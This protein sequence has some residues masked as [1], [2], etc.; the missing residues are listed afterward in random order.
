MVRSADALRGI[1]AQPPWRRVTAAR[2]ANVPHIP[3]NKSPGRR[4]VF[5]GHRIVAATFFF[6]LVF[7]GCGFYAFGLFVTPLETE[8]AWTRREIMTG[9][10]IYFLT[11]GALG[12]LI[13][14][15]VDRFGPRGVMV[16]GALVSGAGFMLLGQMQQLWQFYAVYPFIGAGMAAVGIVPITAVVSNWYRRRRGM[17]IGI[18]SAGLGAGGLALA[19]LIGGAIIPALGW[20]IAYPVMAGFIW[21]IIPVVLLVIRTRPSDMGLLPD[22]DEEPDEGTAPGQATLPPPGLSLREAIATGA[23]WLTALSFLAFGFSEVTIL[24]NQVPFLEGIGF[25][26]ALA[27]GVLGGV[28]L[29]S[30]I[31]KFGFGWLCDRV[32]VKYV[33]AFGL[34]L[35]FAGTIVLMNI[36]PD[37]SE[38]VLWTYA[39]LMGLGVGSWLPA[40]SML[41]SSN[42]G[43]ASYGVIF[44][45]IGFVQAAGGATGPL[46]AGHLF[47]TM[48]TYDLVFILLAGSY[49]VSTLSVLAVRRPASRQVPAGETVPKT[50]II[51]SKKA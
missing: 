15:L 40:M 12:P 3:G 44:G 20:R 23:F 11:S 35:Q 19:P 43:M 25:P 47:D 38:A 13:G 18:M 10:T 28:G 27:A 2:K 9:S 46:M 7:S 5:Y 14:R 48:G 31:G 51:D 21:A 32:P 30:T 34:A 26:V 6:A 42:F 1:Q 16:A 37:S 39:V 4:R 8:L 49:V 29:W 33:C 45:M 41:V 22:G 36:G 24:Q 50:A 17:A